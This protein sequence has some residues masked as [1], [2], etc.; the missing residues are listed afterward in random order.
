MNKKIILGITTSM[1]LASSVFAFNGQENMKKGYY[2][3]NAHH[4]MMKKNSNNKKKNK[5]IQMVTMLDLSDDQK[6]KIRKI[7]KNSMNET[8]SPL[9][10]FTVDSF[11]KMKFIKLVEE[12]RDNKIKRKANVIAKVYGVL[13]SPQKKDLKTIMNMKEIKRK[14][15]M[16]HIGGFSGKNCGRK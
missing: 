1:L 12:K 7:M 15:M 16:N 8:V 11:D 13:T 2:Q 5:I 10:A 6:V 9:S 4:K 14:K 3:N